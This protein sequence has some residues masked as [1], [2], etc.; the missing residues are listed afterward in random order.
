MAGCTCCSGSAV[1]LAET[2]CIE[3]KIS[4]LESLPVGEINWTGLLRRHGGCCEGKKMMEDGEVE[5]S[6]YRS[7]GSD[8]A[9][10]AQVD[11]PSD[12]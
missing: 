2:I 3:V 10:P 11:D 12:N 9:G 4:P 1:I 7:V 6:T 5:L 8:K